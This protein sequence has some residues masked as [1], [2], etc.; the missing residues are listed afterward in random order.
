[1]TPSG[2]T[3]SD[4]QPGI[5]GYA[6]VTIGGQTGIYAFA[7]DDPNPQFFCNLF[8]HISPLAGG[9]IKQD[10]RT[11]LQ[12]PY[13][14]SSLTEQDSI[15][16]RNWVGVLEA[17]LLDNLQAHEIQSSTPSTD[18]G[19]QHR[20]RT[21]ELLTGQS[22]LHA[23][24]GHNVNNNIV[25]LYDVVGNNTSLITTLTT[26]ADAAASSGL[27]ADSD[28]VV[29]EVVYN[30]TRVAETIIT[31]ISPHDNNKHSITLD[32]LA[33]AASAI[34]SVPLYKLTEYCEGIGCYL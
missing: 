7:M 6:N 28:Y 17:S 3:G 12:G 27:R 15:P 21:W 11:H 24:M 26:K 33:S 25:A 14:S 5:Q 1:M 9:S 29:T 18:I 30:S 32:V 4:F 2:W 10:R 22:P 13:P 31:L 23:T 34:F 20:I 19:F 16:D 8:T